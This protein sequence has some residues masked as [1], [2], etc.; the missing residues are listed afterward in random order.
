MS[1]LQVSSYTASLIAIQVLFRR[2]SDRAVLHTYYLYKSFSSPP[3]HHNNMEDTNHQGNDDNAD[4]SGDIAVESSETAEED[5]DDGYEDNDWPHYDNL[6]EETFQKIKQNDPSITNLSVW[7]DGKCFFNSIDW[8]EDG[9]CIANNTHLKRLQ[10]IFHGRCLGRPRGEHYILGEEGHNLPTRQQLQDFFSCIYRNSSI[11]TLVIESISV[12]DEFGGG[13]IE[14]L[15]GH[16]SLTR[17]DVGIKYSV[18]DSDSEAKW[19]II[20][21]KAI[22][23]VLNHPRSKLK[24]LRVSHTKLDDESIQTL[25]EAL[26]GNNVLKRLCLRGTGNRGISSAGWQALATVMRHPNCK[27]TNLSLSSNTIND[28]GV[29]I[30]GWGLSGSSVKALNLWSNKINRVGWQIL[31]LHLSQTSLES[32]N[33]RQNSIEADVLALLGSIRSLKSLNLSGNRSI[34]PAGWQFLFNSLQMSGTQLK[35]L[36]ISHNQIGN[37]G[38]IAL[39]GLLCNMSTLKMLNMDSLSYTGWHASSIITSHGWRVFFTTLQDSNFELV[40]L[41]LN[42]N[43]IDD[44]GIQLLVLLVSRVSTLRNLR[45]KDNRSVT[46]TGWLALSDYLQSPN[47]ALEELLIEINNHTDDTMVAFANLLAH[48]KTLTI[49]SLG[50]TWDEDSSDEED[51]N[52]NNNNN[53]NN[54]LITERGWEAVSTLLCNKT[55]ILDTYNSNHTLQYVSE[56]YSDEIRAKLLPYLELN[57]NKDKAEVARQKILQTHFS[58]EDD[59]QEFLGMELEIMPSA[60]AWIGKPLPIGWIGK[61]VSGLSTMYNLSRKLPDLFDSSAQK[62]QS[63]G[64]KKG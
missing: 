17:L 4:N 18:L 49:I 15:Q 28:D 8:K 52:N 53:N 39:G 44:E 7:L 46:P 10:L 48:N 14:G 34:G 31:L 21:Y 61:N 63:V 56:Y 3:T 54:E 24:V 58:S 23:K 6:Y 13:L 59:L 26:M 41:Y 2:W 43:N 47:F 40:K 12:D 32:L 33:L 57:D 5:S 45:L 30:L 1:P 35:K 11:D 37:V 60:I 64:K 16:P 38:V 62:K 9:C 29:S 42:N 19:G 50:G 20:G 22:G 55:S 27:L 36:D 25:S 51:N